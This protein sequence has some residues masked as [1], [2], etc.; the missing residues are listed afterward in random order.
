[1]SLSLSCRS[2]YPFAL[3][4]FAE[5]PRHQRGAMRVLDVPAGGGVLACALA[6]AGFDVT[7]A[8]LFPEYLARTQS[9]QTAADA[10][11]QFEE[12]CGA[13]LP[14]WLAAELFAGGAPAQRGLA[15]AAADME[16]TLPFADGS[17]DRVA[18]V[19]GIE[20][21]VDR[22]RTLRELR[23][24]LR[25]GGRLIITTP[26]LMS[27]RARLAF[28]LAGQRAFKS[29]VDEHTSVW[30]RS[31][32]GSR[33]YHGHAFL[34][35][36]FQIRYSLHHCGFRIRRLLPSNW[37]VSSVALSPIALL[38]ALGTLYSQRGAKKKFSRIARGDAGD[39]S[40]RPP[41]GTVPP[42]AEM[43]SHLLSP[44]LLFNATMVI[45]AEAREESA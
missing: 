16:G 9:R 36:Y 20:H 41:L 26:N 30:G 18:C 23:R 27:L 33:T 34:L 10:R 37:S 19:E 1:M 28:A 15:G 6:A 5:T 11:G 13:R 2:L 43:F 38:V 32:D 24:V 25:P 17:F 31:P 44:E 4:P 12:M 14:E 8:D 35:T 21:V 7:A 40:Y 3:I 39:L 22:H 45:E 42:Y 29:Y